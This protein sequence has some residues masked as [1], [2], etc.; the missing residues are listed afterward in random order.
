MLMTLDGESTDIGTGAELGLKGGPLLHPHCGPL[1]FSSVLT[2]RFVV[3]T[4]S[5]LQNELPYQSLAVDFR[6]GWSD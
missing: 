6:R 3:Q 1:G 4:E 5:E 2:C